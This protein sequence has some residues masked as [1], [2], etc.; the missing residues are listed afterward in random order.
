MRQSIRFPDAAFKDIPTIR[1]LTLP[2]KPS[3]VVL[4]SPHTNEHPATLPFQRALAEKLEHMG[5]KTEQMQNDGGMESGWSIRKKI[6]AGELAGSNKACGCALSIWDY[7]QRVRQISGIF[8]KYNGK[9]STYVMEVHAMNSL[10]P[11]DPIFFPVSEFRRIADT[12]ILIQ[13]FASMGFEA[14]KVYSKELD[15]NERRFARD[16]A[17]QLSFNLVEAIMEIQGRLRGIKK[18]AKNA[19]LI[20][21]P[22][23]EVKLPPNH[24]AFS[25][26][27]ESP[28]C[29][30]SPISGFEHGYCISTRE[31]IGAE[32][33]HLGA[34]AAIFL[35][36]NIKRKPPKEEKP[37]GTPF[38][39]SGSAGIKPGLLI[40]EGSTITTPDG[41]VLRRIS[42]QQASDLKA[43]KH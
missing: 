32:K 31:S 14:L 9:T 42:P 24:P 43:G 3:R 15:E 20:E 6:L 33:R 16:V 29:L 22:G 27:F 40:P 38:F 18:S 34:V 37:A 41:R 36:P 13:Y 17:T 4:L 2:S 7:L 35:S 12:P 21:V 23:I 39:T 8:A 10:A 25:V 19:L 5:V 1:R 11:N 26:Y 30:L 28:N